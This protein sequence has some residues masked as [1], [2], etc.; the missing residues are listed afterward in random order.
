MMQYFMLLLYEQM[1]YA[2]SLGSIFDM[3]GTQVQEEKI[4]RYLLEIFWEI[5]NVIGEMLKIDCIELF[6]EIMRLF[7]PVFEKKPAAW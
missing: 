1:H 2:Q 5:V 6:E 3:P 4:S 7:S